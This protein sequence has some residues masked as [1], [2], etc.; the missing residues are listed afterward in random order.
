MKTN[1]IIKTALF[2][3][4]SVVLSATA[5]A[6]PT[7]PADYVTFQKAGESIDTVT[8]GSR[9]AYK[10][11]GDP[12]INALVTAGKMAASEYKWVFSN[13]A[14]VLK[15]DGT[16]PATASSIAGHTGYFKDKE[17]NV[18]MPTTPQALT[19]TI[20]E[21]SM[22]LG[23]TAGCEGTD[24]VANIQVVNRPTIGWNG[25]PETGGCSVADVPIS[26]SL[27]GYGQWQVSYTISFV[28]HDGTGSVAP[29]V[30]TNV[31]LGATGKKAGNYSLTIPSTDL[32]NGEGVYTV[33]VT[34]L[35]D[36]ISR[37]SLDPIASVASDLPTGT[38]K[39]NV[40]PTPKTKKL[41]H[42]KNMP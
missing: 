41:Q 16:T 37:K 1:I 10:V 7:L 6:Q 17:I 21:W 33:T 13:S 12:T 38:Y 42:V 34:N 18:K 30:F 25:T 19:L 27:T 2:A 24:S 14:A 11:D 29:V 15:T 36:R 23:G 3:V 40:Y 4:A 8:V 31:P 28:K 22:L 20:N 26:V 9:M 32:V 35:N 39:I 5:W